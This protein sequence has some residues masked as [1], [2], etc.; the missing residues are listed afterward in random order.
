MKIDDISQGAA[1][2]ERLRRAAASARQI[3]EAQLRAILRQNAKTA[4]GARWGFSRIRSL[5]DFQE[6]VPLSRYPD[7]EPY[8]QALLAGDTRQLTAEEPVYFAITSGSTGVPK[9]VPV[10]AADMAVH[11]DLIHWGVWGMVEEHFPQT[12]PEALFGRIFQVGEF[13]KTRLPG[14]QLCGIRS[15]SLYQ[16]LDREGGFDAS[17]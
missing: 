8:V 2:L 7:Y 1:A 13:A 15:A 16:W 17:P 6:R 10:T 4:Y 5:A 3:Q 12:P 11:R 9:Y 14:G